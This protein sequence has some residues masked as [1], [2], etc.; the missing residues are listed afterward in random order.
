MSAYAAPTWAKARS[1]FAAFGP[2]LAATRPPTLP[3]AALLP[4]RRDVAIATPVGRPSWQLAQ[5]SLANPWTRV[6]QHQNLHL[7]EQLVETIPLLNAA[8]ERIVQLV[9]CPKIEADDEDQ[10]N[11]LLAWWQNLSVNRIMTGGRNWFSGWL[12]DALTYGRSHAEIILRADRTDI[13]ALQELHSRTIDLRPLPDGYGIEIVQ[14]NRGG[15]PVVL[16][17]ELILTA[18]HDVRNDSPQG[19]SLLYGL[20]FAGEIY[21]KLLFSLKETWTRFGTPTYHVAW[22]PPEGFNDPTGAKGAVVAQGFSA[23]LTDAL[24]SRANGDVRDF[25]TVGDTT[26]SII[27]ANGETLDI[28]IPGRHLLEQ[29]VAKTGLP[30]MLLGLQWQAGERIGAV[31]AGLV[32]EMIDEIRG[33]L[34]APIRY[35]FRLRQALVGRPFDFQLCWEAPSLM[36]AIETAQAEAQQA[37]ADLNRLKLHERLWTLGIEANIEVAREFKPELEGKDDAEVR[38]RLPNLL[39]EPPAPLALPPAGGGGN[40]PNGGPGEPPLGTP[41]GRRVTYGDAWPAKNGNGRHS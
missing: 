2:D 13:Y 7:Y 8:L 11:D 36:D 3:A 33:H 40:P 39:A 15:G 29:I 35:L 34:E 16:P 5:A 17:R 24:K 21:E 38:R 32:S 12:M 25:I 27:G 22:T 28:Q 37:M 14:L 23:A 20:L 41:F 6:P 18:V 9:G 10:A 26:V 4:E 31:Q 30:P 19:N 1:P